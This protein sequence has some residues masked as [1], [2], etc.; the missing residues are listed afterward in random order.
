MEENR[1]FFSYGPFSEE[2]A[3]SR[4]DKFEE[5]LAK[6]ELKW[7]RIDDVYAELKRLHPWL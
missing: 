3:I 4:I 7:M 1:R 5:K 6:G 2:K